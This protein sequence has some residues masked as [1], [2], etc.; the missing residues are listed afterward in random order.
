MKDCCHLEHSSINTSTMACLK[1][2]GKNIHIHIQEFKNNKNENNKA[3]CC[4]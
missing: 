1:A 4:R 3:N 2:V